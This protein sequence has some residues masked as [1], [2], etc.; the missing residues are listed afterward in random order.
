MITYVWI[1]VGAAL[2]AFAAWRAVPIWLDTRRHGWN[3]ARR[4]GW[5]LLGIVVPSRYWWQARIEALGP[6]DRA[7]LL[8]HETKALGLSRADALRCPLCGAEVPEAWAL[9]SGREVH[10]AEGPVRCPECD[11]RLDA[12]R[13]CVNFLPGSPRSWSGLG[14]LDNDRTHG[15]CSHY[16]RVQPVEQA[17]GPDMARQLKARGYDQIR[18]PMQIVDSY[19]RPDFCRAFQADPG[20]VKASDIRWPGPRRRALLRLLEARPAGTG[21]SQGELTEEQQWLI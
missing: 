19:L 12:C 7:A 21:R 15:R 8:Q 9:E 18:A 11:F 16:K 17:A 20:R 5:S 2:L 13:H 3:R 4:L 6:E 10:V 14:W 1:A